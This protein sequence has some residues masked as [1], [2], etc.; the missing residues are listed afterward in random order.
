MQNGYLGY[1]QMM[2][3]E[4]AA[5]GQFR[6]QPVFMT[7]HCEYHYTDVIIDLPDRKRGL[8]DA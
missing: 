1:Y 4:Q 3:F 2:A 6:Q 7:S 5:D 8:A